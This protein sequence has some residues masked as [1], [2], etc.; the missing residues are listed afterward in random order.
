MAF[1]VERKYVSANPVSQV[2]A[3]RNGK[4]TVRPVTPLAVGDLVTARKIIM[5]MPD[6]VYKDFVLTVLLAGVAT[7]DSS[8]RPVDTKLCLSGPTDTSRHK[9]GWLG[10]RSL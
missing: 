4:V 9:S 8:W 10:W 5:E 2:K 1:A 7:I 3:K 6:G